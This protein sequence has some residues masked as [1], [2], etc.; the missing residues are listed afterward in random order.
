MVTLPLR[1]LFGFCLRAFLLVLLCVGGSTLLRAEPDDAH[2][3]VLEK[4]IQSE[5]AVLNDAELSRMSG[6]QKAYRWAMLG[7][8][9]A[10]AADFP[11]SESAYVHA[12]ELLKN[13]PSQRVFYAAVLEK[14]GYLYLTYGRLP[15]ALNC[16]RT[17]LDVRQQIGEPLAI[18][19]SRSHLAEVLLTMRRYGQ[20]EKEAS[21]AYQSMI[22]LDDSEKTDLVSVLVVLAYT[23]CARHS[24][25]QGLADARQ[26]VAISRVVFQPDSMP[27]GAALMVQG[28]A[29]SKTGDVSNAEDTTRRAL[30]ILKVQ[31]APSD[32]RLIHALVQYH[33]CLKSQHKKQEASEVDQQLAAI[34]QRSRQ[35]CMNCSVSVFSMRSTAP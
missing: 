25:S 9:Y 15:E 24:C 35:S 20:A 19:R 23:R 22:E 12:V 31:L 21:A 1:S 32:P 29:E 11:H 26:A 4:H 13:D 30:T 34:Y 28:Y 14:F 6:P 3:A 27:M 16:R 33:D 8:D 10:D 7:S 18:A 17:A 5:V 2:L